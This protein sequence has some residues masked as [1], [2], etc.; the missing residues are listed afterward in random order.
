M[1]RSVLQ[2]VREETGPHDDG[3]ASWVGKAGKCP[4]GQTSSGLILFAISTAA[5]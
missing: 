3:P 1:G 5:G 2:G 4:P